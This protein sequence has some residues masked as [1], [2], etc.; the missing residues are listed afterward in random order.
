MCKVLKPTF[1][2]NEKERLEALWALEVLDTEPEERFDRITRIAQRVFGVPI[3]LVSLVD[4]DRQ[5][6]KSRQGLAATQTPRDISFCG[7]AILEDRPFV[8]EDTSTDPRFADNPL[9][10][11]DPS[12]GFYAGRPLADAKGHRLGTLCLIDRQPRQLDENELAILDDLAKMVESELQLMNTRRLLLKVEAETLARKEAEFE[13][14][15]FFNQSPML[16]CIGDFEGQIRHVNRHWR[17]SLGYDDDS[18]TDQSFLE[19]VHP[20]DRRRTEAEIQGLSRGGEASTFENRMRAKDGSYRTLE[21]AAVVSPRTGRIFG[22]AHDVTHQRELEKALR[23]S[24]KELEQFASVASH[25]LQEP[26]RKVQ[27]FGGRLRSV[28]GDQLDETAQDYMDRML[29][30]TTRMQTLIDELLQYS[31][32]ISKKRSFEPVD[33]AR[34][35]AEVCEDLEISI[36]E[37]EA[38]IE[39]GPLPVVEADATQM[40]QLFQNLIGNAL[41]FRREDV[42]P[43]IRVGLREGSDSPSAL[44]TVE[45]NGIGFDQKYAD[46]IFGVFQR[47]HGRTEFDGSGIGLALCRRIMDGHDGHVHAKASVGDG[48]IFYLEFS[49]AMIVEA[50]LV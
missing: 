23:L 1:P 30:A 18:L 2:S 24:N 37:A 4:G 25:D 33:L 13:R 43:R 12:I 6:F 35:V 20:A 46:R 11:D 9:V 32:V 22:A 45:D 8:V 10:T 50:E 7:H 49:P 3:T 17:K 15:H 44:V 36:Q 38:T 34:V 19:L 40:R 48:S 39:I 47:L 16:F 28:L 27:T 29:G 14:D 21:W 41:K 31:R 5:W 42:R 26:L